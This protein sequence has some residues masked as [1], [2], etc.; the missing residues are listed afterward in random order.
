MIGIAF[1]QFAAKRTTDA[2][3]V[4]AKAAAK[5]SG[6]PAVNVE[7]PSNVTVEAQVVPTETT[8]RPREDSDGAVG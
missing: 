1:G 3:Y 5:A 8:P 4:A 2:E 7:G 6:P